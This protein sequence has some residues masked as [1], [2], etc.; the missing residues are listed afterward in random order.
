MN[1]V[2]WPWGIY[3]VSLTHALCEENGPGYN[4]YLNVLILIFSCAQQGL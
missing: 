3:I 1:K 4:E 2:F